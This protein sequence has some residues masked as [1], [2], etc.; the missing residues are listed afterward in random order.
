VR[1]RTLEAAMHEIRELSTLGRAAREVA[2]VKVRQPLSRLVCVVPAGARLAD[3]QPLAPLLA[4]ELN[5][6]RV[7][8]ANEADN[9]V[10][11]EARANFRSL[12][13]RFGSR[14]PLAAAA[15]VALTS[16]ALMGIERGEEVS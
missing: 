13:K 2:G 15:V 5:V 12:G 11:L 10:T 7:E 14:T 16:E 8:F 1:D 9:L 6:K 4:A 3:I